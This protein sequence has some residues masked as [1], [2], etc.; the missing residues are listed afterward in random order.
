MSATRVQFI[1]TEVY[2]KGQ[3]SI[4]EELRKQSNTIASNN[5]QLRNDLR[6][7]VDERVQQF[8]SELSAAISTVR[9]TNRELGDLR[10]QVNSDMAKLREQVNSDMANLRDTLGEVRANLARME[11]VRM[12][13]TKVRPYEKVEIIGRYVHGEGY[14]EPTVYFPKRVRDFW[15]LKQIP[16]DKDKRVKRST[17][18]LETN[19]MALLL[20][21]SAV[22]HLTYLVDFYGIDDYHH[23][24]KMYANWDENEGHF[25]EELSGNGS[26]SSDSSTSM[27]LEEAVAAH[28]S[29]AVDRLAPVIG[30]DEDKFTEYC[31]RAARYSERPQQ[32]PGKRS[33]YLVGEEYP[34]RPKVQQSPPSPVAKLS[35][36]DFALPDGKPGSSSS[37]SDK[38]NIKYGTPST[39]KAK[40]MESMLARANA[41]QPETPPA[42]DSEGSPT[43]PNSSPIAPQMSPGSGTKAKRGS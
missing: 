33:G 13:A 41:R 30:L 22:Q 31:Q 8:Q 18:L 29:Q 17:Y 12:N 4:E 3:Q 38:T 11:K 20:T 2:A 42:P 16:K 28:P 14:Q 24:G 9:Q 25:D 6:T 27:S 5:Q 35:L 36:R 43:V 40:R 1:T 26:S 23:W 21:L 39:V 37:P 7:E 19:Y 32:H 15:H 10:V 34:K